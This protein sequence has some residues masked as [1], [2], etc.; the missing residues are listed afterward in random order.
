[1]APAATECRS[2]WKSRTSPS[3]PFRVIDVKSPPS[4]LPPPCCSLRSFLGGRR[5]GCCL[6]PSPSVRGAVFPT[7]LFGSCRFLLHPPPLVGGA[8][9]LLLL[10]VLFFHLPSLGG[11]CFR[12][13]VVLRRLQFA[14]VLA[15]IVASLISPQQMLP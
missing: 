3:E 15:T 12:K 4:T 6:L 7:L 1:M 11:C 14:S 13:C 2:T 10:W 8:A 9:V 5:R